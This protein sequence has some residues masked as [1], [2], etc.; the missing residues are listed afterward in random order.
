MLSSLGVT[1]NLPEANATSYVFPIGTFYNFMDI[2]EAT[3]P[4]K[5]HKF[6]ISVEDNNANKVEK[7]LNVTINVQQLKRYIHY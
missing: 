2:Y 1:L 4:G 7:A 3:D 5:T 6:I